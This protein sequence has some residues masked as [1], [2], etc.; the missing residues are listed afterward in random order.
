MAAVWEI[1][2][3]NY[4]LPLLKC[5]LVDSVPWGVLWLRD[6]N[7]F[8]SEQEYIYMYRQQRLALFLCCRADDLLR[9]CGGLTGHRWALAHSC[10]IKTC[11]VK[12]WTECCQQVRE[13][14]HLTVHG[15]ARYWSVF[16]EWHTRWQIYNEVYI[17]E[18]RAG[19]VV[20]RIDPLRFLA[21]CRTRR[22][23]HV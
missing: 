17:T 22:L 7:R 11:L 20:V 21:G 5:A 8:V 1:A 15:F 13:W 4:S 2:R 18:P 12:L 6:K 23:N 16:Y 19:S 10:A 3:G 9:S 14:K